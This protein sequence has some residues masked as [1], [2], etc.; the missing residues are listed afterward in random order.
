MPPHALPLPPRR[1]GRL[2]LCL[3]PF[4]IAGF[5][6]AWILLASATGR[7]SSWMALLAAV[8]AAVLLRIGGMAPGVRRATWAVAATIATIVLAHWGIVAAGIG[9]LVGLGPIDSA[10]K[11]GTGL[12]WTV[13]QLLNG[14]LDVA[15]LVA[16]L[17]VAILA[18]R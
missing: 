17:G 12:A 6:A 4:G 8:D 18:G 13:A 16:S 2:A 14:P 5:A 1:R 15:L 9:R 7:Q 3:L 11:L 10:L